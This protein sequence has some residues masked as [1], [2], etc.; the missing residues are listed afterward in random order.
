MIHLSPE[1]P[2]PA[3]GTTASKTGLKR[4]IKT[5]TKGMNDQKHKFFYR[6]RKIASLQNSIMSHKRAFECGL[7]LY[8]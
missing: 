2:Q 8:I 6:T 5:T 4:L 7:Q 3:T 1:T